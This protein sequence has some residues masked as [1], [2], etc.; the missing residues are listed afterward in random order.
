MQSVHSELQKSLHPILHY[1]TLST[2]YGAAAE[3]SSKAQKGAPWYPT[4]VN[5]NREIL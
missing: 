2:V 4:K 5:G 1:S 3:K